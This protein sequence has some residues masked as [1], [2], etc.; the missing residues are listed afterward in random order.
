MSLGPFAFEALGFG[1][2]NIGRRLST[3]W[4]GIEVAQTL[5]RQQW[6]GPTSDEVTI[7]GVLFPEEFGG[8]ASLD[9]L[10]AAA[11]AGEPL[12][13]VSGDASEG[14]ISGYFTIHG[15]DEDRSYIDARGRAHRNAYQIKLMRYEGPA[16]G[17]SPLNSFLNL[18]G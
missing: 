7:R 2:Q 17:P 6:T 10:I 18:F 9:G 14:I 12:M 1:Y 16:P 3:P 13:F 4:A 15:I 5:D 8:Q 11:N